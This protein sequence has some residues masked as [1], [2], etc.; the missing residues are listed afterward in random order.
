MDRIPIAFEHE[1]KKFSG[2]FAQVMGAG[3]GAVWHL[4]DDQKYYLGQLRIGWEDQWY[5]DE[6]KPANKLSGLAQFFGDY[7]TAWVE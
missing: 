4:Y 7:I 6:S 3:S 1:G 2:Y 5:F